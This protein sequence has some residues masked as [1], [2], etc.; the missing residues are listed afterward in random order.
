LDRIELDDTGMCCACIVVGI[1]ED[2]LEMLKK[3]KRRE[4]EE[5]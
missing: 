4:I 5:E 3:R 1:E 2:L